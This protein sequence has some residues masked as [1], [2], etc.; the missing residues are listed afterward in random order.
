MD[1]NWNYQLP[2]GLAPPLALPPLDRKI[3][4]KNNKNSTVKITYPMAAWWAPCLAFW[5]VPGF[6]L[7]LLWL[8]DTNLILF[9]DKKTKL[10]ATFSKF[11]TRFEFLYK[12]KILFLSEFKIKYFPHGLA[13]FFKPSPVRHI[14]YVSVLASFRLRLLYLF[15]SS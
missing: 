5:W 1:G 11:S 2:W 12:G 13:F 7:V 15:C 8:W 10:L 3:K 9:S 4:V 6:V 14:L